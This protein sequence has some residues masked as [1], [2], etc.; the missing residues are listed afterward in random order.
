M[1]LMAVKECLKCGRMY[2]PI[3]EFQL[4]CS[5]PCGEA[6]G[7]GLKEVEAVRAILAQQWW[8]AQ[9]ISLGYNR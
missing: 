6:A 5:A 4:C 9:M 7:R 2:A 1:R 8:D 3:V